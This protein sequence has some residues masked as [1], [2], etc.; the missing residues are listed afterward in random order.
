M[1]DGGSHKPELYTP[2]RFILNIKIGELKDQPSET[3]SLLED[4]ENKLVDA[5]TL[6]EQKEGQINNL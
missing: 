4:K 3:E 2:N 6:L 1:G 5:G